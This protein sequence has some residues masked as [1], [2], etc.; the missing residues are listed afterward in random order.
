MDCPGVR[1]DYTRLTYTLVGS[2][3]A[4]WAR[5]LENGLAVDEQV[6]MKTSIER[7]AQGSPAGINR[8]PPKVLQGGLLYYHR[9]NFPMVKKA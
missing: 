4:S 2:G 1:T 6:E 7:R 3:A 8:H 5:I 9:R